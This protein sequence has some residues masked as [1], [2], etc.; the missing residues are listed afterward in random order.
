RVPRPGDCAILCGEPSEPLHTR[1][2]WIVVADLPTTPCCRGL[3]N[4]LFTG[5]ARVLLH[6]HR[7]V[8][9]GRGL[10]SLPLASHRRRIATVSSGRARA[11]RVPERAVAAR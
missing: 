9:G 4:D 10:V 8:H 2:Q 3:S 7:P 5:A 1:Q 11:W 6:D